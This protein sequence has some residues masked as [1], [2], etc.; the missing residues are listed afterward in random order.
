MSIE[1]TRGGQ[2]IYTVYDDKG[3]III[4]T[5]ERYIAEKAEKNGRI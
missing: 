5:T 1:V 2:L 4:R 3:Y